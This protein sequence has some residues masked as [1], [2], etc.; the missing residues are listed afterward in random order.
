MDHPLRRRGTCHVFGDDI[1]LDEG[2]IPFS[3][4]IGRETRPDV[5]I[6]HLFATLDA[7]FASRVAPGDIILGG[8]QFAC[9]KTHVQ[10]FIAMAALQLGIVCA[11]M[12]FKAMR[13]AVAQGLPVITGLADPD[14]F[15]KTGDILEVDYASGLVSNVST[16][17]VRACQGMPPVLQPIIEQGGTSG[18]LR[19]W[20]AAHPHMRSPLPDTDAAH[21]RTTH[22]DATARRII[23][24]TQTEPAHA[25]KP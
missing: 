6:P 9:G 15:A 25:R 11:S 17:A 13:R 22:G 5:L 7:G 24:N 16:G 12:P 3:L 2:F 4:A 23:I 14:T 19:Y 10:G 1:P 18:Y 21:V 20:L 8:K